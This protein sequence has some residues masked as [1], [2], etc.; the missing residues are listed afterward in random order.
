MAMPDDPSVLIALSSALAR[1]AEDHRMDALVAFAKRADMRLEIGEFMVNSSVHF[2]PDSR[3]TKAFI[4]WES[5]LNA[6]Q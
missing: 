6:M 3:F 5:H 1:Q 2:N 4:A